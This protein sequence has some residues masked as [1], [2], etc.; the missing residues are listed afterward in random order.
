M[1][2]IEADILGKPVVSTDI[3]GPRSFMLEHGGRLV[4]NSE[5]GIYQC[6]LYNL[7]PEV[8][9]VPITATQYLDKFLPH[10]SL[11]IFLHVLT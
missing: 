11:L 8:S 3:V 5:E 6:M 9:L 2:L 4:E 10:C 7:L 1:A